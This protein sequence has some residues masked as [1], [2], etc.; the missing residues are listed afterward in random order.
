MANTPSGDRVFEPTTE[1]SAVTQMADA[2]HVRASYAPNRGKVR[3][4]YPS[5]LINPQSR[6]FISVSEGQ[7]AT[8]F[9]GAAS[10]TVENVAAG[11]GEVQF[12]VFIDWPSNLG[13]VA[14]FFWVNP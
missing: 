8:K 3:Y 11:N 1:S 5:S 4:R 14:D 7:G 10:M 6:V 13:M 12:R 2:Y 9:V